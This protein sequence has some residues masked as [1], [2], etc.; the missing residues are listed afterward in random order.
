MLICLTLTLESGA[1]FLQLVT[2]ILA[3]TLE[4]FTS[5][6]RIQSLVSLIVIAKI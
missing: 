6:K 4:A 2:L 1:I 3:L 5:S